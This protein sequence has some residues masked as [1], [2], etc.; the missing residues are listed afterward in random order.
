M[1]ISNIVALILGGT[2]F[3]ISIIGLI[4][5]PKLNLKSRQLEER[6]K[7]RFILFQKVLELQEFTTKNTIENQNEFNPLMQEV[8]KLIQLYGYG[9]ETKSFQEVLNSYKNF[10]EEINS[11]PGENRKTR[12]TIAANQFKSKLESFFSL[13]VNAYRKELVLGK[14]EI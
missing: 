1:D 8:Y 3:V 7:Y 6:L 9:A 5:T 2:G 13:S 10:A 4:V 14:L 11:G 12:I